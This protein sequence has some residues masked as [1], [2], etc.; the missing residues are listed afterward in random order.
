MSSLTIENAPILSNSFNDE[1][2][3]FNGI[4]LI[5]K[6][7]NIL[8]ILG[9]DK[10][11]M[12]DDATNFNNSRTHNYALEGTIQLMEN[13]VGCPKEDIQR[14]MECFV[15]KAAVH[16][17]NIQWQY[18]E[19]ST[20]RLELILRAMSSA[21]HVLSNFVTKIE[22]DTRDSLYK[23]FSK[24]WAIY[25]NSKCINANVVFSLREIRNCLRLIKVDQSIEPTIKV[26]FDTIINI[27][28]SE[29]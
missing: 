8:S 24:F 27:I 28:Q 21:L 13:L 10:R 3:E 6:Y 12:L 17:S 26:G 9:D 25:R 5:K 7:E 11:N 22:A 15:P 19:G 20:A 4:N 2:L 14:G 29:Y 16:I 23:S 18:Y 1:N